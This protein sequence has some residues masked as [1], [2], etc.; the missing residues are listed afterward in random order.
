MTYLYSFF[1]VVLL[2][3]LIYYV[4]GVYFCVGVE[5]TRPEIIQRM[6]KHPKQCKF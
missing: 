3:F 6:Y 5:D 4:G 1:V 2:G